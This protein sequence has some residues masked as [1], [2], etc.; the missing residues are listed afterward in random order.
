MDREILEAIGDEIASEA[1]K[2]RDE[3][4][5]ELI[6]SGDCISCGNYPKTLHSVVRNVI[7]FLGL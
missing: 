3:E 4:L 7:S 1:T 6:H 2:A 5:W